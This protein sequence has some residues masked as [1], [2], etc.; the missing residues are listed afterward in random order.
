M[1]GRAQRRARLVGRAALVA[2]SVSLMAPAPA[3]ADF[4]CWLF[5]SGCNGGGPATQQTS[6]RAA[7]P[8][9]DPNALVNA[10]A[11]VAG[12]AAILADR[13]RRRR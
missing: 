9:I 3:H 1:R 13:V 2:L 8:E 4:W 10:L 6:E 12:G 11:L 7:A 5:N